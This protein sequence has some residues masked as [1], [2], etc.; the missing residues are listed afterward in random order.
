LE[1]YIREASDDS[2]SGSSSQT[3]ERGKKLAQQMDLFSFDDTKF[4]DAHAPHEDSDSDDEKGHDNYNYG[5]QQQQQVSNC[6]KLI[7]KYC[8]VPQRSASNTNVGNQPSFD[9]FGFEAEATTSHDALPTFSTTTSNNIFDDPF[10]G[11]TPTQQQNSKF[12]LLLCV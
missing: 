8:K 4:N 11:P 7:L 6:P 3:S 2:R 10:G 12:Q 1:N 5:S 9:P